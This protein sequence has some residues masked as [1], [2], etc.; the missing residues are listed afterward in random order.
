MP[1]ETE[2]RNTNRAPQTGRAEQPR[3]SSAEPPF[4]LAVAL[5][6][7]E[8]LAKPPRMPP[9]NVRVRVKTSPWVRRALPTRL[10][11]ARAARQ[12]EAIWE[13]SEG[14]REGA[15]ATMEAIVSGT[16]RAGEA[17]ELARLHLIERRVD[18]VLFWEQPWSASMDAVS[19]ARV[20]EALSGE[21]GV[22]L[23]ACH[24]GPFYRSMY[25]MP[26]GRAQQYTI[27]GPWLFEPPSH[28]YWGRR[29]ARWR[30][31]ALGRKVP[32]EGS[33]QL[34][35]SLLARGD[36]VYVFY[37]MPGRRETRFLGKRAL[38]ADGS[39]RLAV[40]SDAL[41][42]GLRSRREGHEVRVDAAEP[43]DP[44]ELGGVE[45][46]HAALGALHERWILERP[47]EM[48]DPNSF[49]WEHGAGPEAWVRPPRERA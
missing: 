21:R 37:D 30:K 18:T 28:D 46:V 24:T 14:E 11:V 10:L 36:C 17:R 34:L 7:V 31:G 42:L 22:L 5:A 25:S 3:A 47:Q 8:R 32:A 38:L 6:E 26:V 4:D 16:A 41:I 13:H 40:E 44:R 39:A 43:L 35:A 20:R 27:F 45:E 29:V 48:A 9:C 15:I 12:A 2:D 49:G 19:A 1:T 23:S 33:Y